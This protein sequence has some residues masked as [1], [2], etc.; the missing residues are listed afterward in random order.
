[1]KLNVALRLMIELLLRVAPRNIY[2]GYS[3][4]KKYDICCGA[5]RSS[6]DNQQCLSRDSSE[7]CL[8]VC[9]L[10]LLIHFAKYEIYAVEVK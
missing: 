5:H 3:V 2:K 7:L 4:S 9:S 10:E 8:Y 1:M 6:V